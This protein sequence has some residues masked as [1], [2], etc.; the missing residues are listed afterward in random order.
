[1]FIRYCASTSVVTSVSSLVVAL[2]VASHS[3]TSRST[4]AGVSVADSDVSLTS[5]GEIISVY[6]SSPRTAPLEFTEPA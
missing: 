5:S 4:G 1:M 3:R 6:S 2:V